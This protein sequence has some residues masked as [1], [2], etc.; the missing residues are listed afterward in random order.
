MMNTKECMPLTGVL[1]YY[2]TISVVGHFVPLFIMFSVTL[3]KYEDPHHQD[4]RRYGHHWVLGNTGKHN[5]HCWQHM[6]WNLE[7][8]TK[9]DLWLVFFSDLTLSCSLYGST[10]QRQSTCKLSKFSIL[11]DALYEEN[12]GLSL[13]HLFL[14]FF[15]FF[16]STRFTLFEVFYIWI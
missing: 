11:T 9:T 10:G 12:I 4:M 3:G 1:D 2:I 8:K 5:P 7:K 15:F 14:F 6:S 13:S 16:S